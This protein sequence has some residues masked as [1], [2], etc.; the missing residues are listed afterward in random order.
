MYHGG[1][2]P[3]VSVVTVTKRPGSIDITWDGLLAQ[4]LQEFEWVLC[5]ELF[6]GRAAEVRSFVDDPRLVHIPA[7]VRAGHLWN[8]NKAYNE[9][10]RHCRGELVVSLQDY[11]WIPPGALQQFW[12]AYEDRGPKTFVC[13]VTATYALPA[14][15]RR[16]DGAVTIFERPWTGPP[17][18]LVRVDEDR[19]CFPPGVSNASAHHWEINWGGAPL[20]ALFDVGGFAEEHDT[21]FYSCDNVTVAA[22]A[23]HL[24]YDFVLDR[25]N[26]CRAIDH[27]DVFPKPADWEERHGKFGPWEAWYRRWKAERC[28][29]FAYLTP[30][31]QGDAA[32]RR[33]PRRAGR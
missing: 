17:D 2:T 33:S 4:T 3:S 26:I 9:A 1:D 32:V 16:P 24:G 27:S 13:G 22:V 20:A 8:L 11:I 19:F 30:E 25:D 29:R 31:R 21:L 23:E 12:H 5:D 14:E 28:P 18:Q 7:P 10:L 15:I 6:D